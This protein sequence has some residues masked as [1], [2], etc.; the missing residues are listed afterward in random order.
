MSHH[1]L[2]YEKSA[3]DADN[4][5]V[6]DSDESSFCFL[7]RLDNE[8]VVESVRRFEYK[9]PVDAKQSVK[10]KLDLSNL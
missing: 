7:N 4:S 9:H 3:H 5:V 6:N 10:L 8:S 2:H 1:Y